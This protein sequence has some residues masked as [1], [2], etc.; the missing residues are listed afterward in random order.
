MYFTKPAAVFLD[1]VY[2]YDLKIPLNY[3]SASIS[4]IELLPALRIMGDLSFP[5]IV[6]ISLTDKLKLFG[7]DAGT[8]VYDMP[9]FSGTTTFISPNYAYRSVKDPMPDLR[10][11]LY[12]NAQPDVR[13][14]E[15]YTSDIPGEYVIEV[16]AVDNDGNIQRAFSTFKVSGQ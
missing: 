14:I 15:F 1:G 8:C 4:K 2:A 7:F 5:G 13:D 11:L 6:S 12:W 10:Q 3:H 16:E 9:S